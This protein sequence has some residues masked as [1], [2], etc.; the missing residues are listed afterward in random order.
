MR[1][2]RVA[3]TLLAVGLTFVVGTVA[4]A[5]P[6]GAG[7]R[8]FL[9]DDTLLTGITLSEAQR[10]DVAQ[11]RKLQLA[12]ADGARVEFLDAVELMRRARERGDD[13]TAGTIMAVL[14]SDMKS[15][16]TW[17][18]AAL[19]ALLTPEQRR[20]FDTNVDALMAAQGSTAAEPP[21]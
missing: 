11:L 21:T 7:D 20:L 8:P 2:T 6:A 16:Q 17:R 15:Q 1:I 18:L 9:L 14:Q 5:Q 4:G 12:E 3:R 19:R 10:E 13:G